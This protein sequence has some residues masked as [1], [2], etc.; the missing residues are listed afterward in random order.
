MISVI[1]AAIEDDDDKAFMRN[2][3]QD[4]SAL[5]RSTVYTVMRCENDI[6]DLAEDVFVKLIEKIP[7]LRTFD[8]CKT[9]AYVVY[10]ARSVAINFIKH[11]DVQQKHTFYGEKADVSDELMIPE[12]TLEE[13]YYHR[14]ELE[15][16]SDAV[17]RLPDREKDILYF[18]YIL[19]KTDAE[20]A[21]DL[22]ISPGSVREYLTRARRAAKKL[23]EQGE[24]RNDS[25]KL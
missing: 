19:E 1:I 4:Y 20:I 23:M 14:E 12:G 13:V 17:L 15:A 6:D 8:C 21:E 22:S 16:L 18:K 25:P 7:L 11:R 5:V 2:L 3:Y 9:A 10:T 24:K